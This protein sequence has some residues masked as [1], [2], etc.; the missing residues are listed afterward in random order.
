[1]ILSV[2]VMSQNTFGKC[3]ENGKPYE[4][5]V[6]MIPLE[7][8]REKRI[9]IILRRLVSLLTTR[10]YRSCSLRISEQAREYYN[11]DCNLNAHRVM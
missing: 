6:E 5:S 1:M 10:F 2:M 7:M 11:H 3:A 9:F 8:Q 4:S